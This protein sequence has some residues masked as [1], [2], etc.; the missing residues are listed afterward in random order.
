MKLSVFVDRCCAP[1]CG[2]LD[3]LI[4][5]YADASDRSD[6]CEIHKEM[7]RG[8]H[9]FDAAECCIKLADPSEIVR[10]FA[11]VFRREPHRTADDVMKWSGA[12]ER[13]R[14]EITRLWGVR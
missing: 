1:G 8:G 7:V 5:D 4:Q 14:A 10:R 11:T 2:S 6:L 13:L 9:V 3:A 12:P